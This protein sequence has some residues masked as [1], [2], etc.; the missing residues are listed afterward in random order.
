MLILDKLLFWVPKLTWKNQPT[1]KGI[2]PDLN[3][4]ILSQSY[5]RNFHT[6]M[7][8]GANVRTA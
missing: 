2:Q 5:Y 4:I 1:K 7:A 8:S 6:T 3:S